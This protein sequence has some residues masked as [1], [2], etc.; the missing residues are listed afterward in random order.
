M[1]LM[2]CALMATSLAAA[3]EVS[4]VLASPEVRAEWDAWQERQGAPRSPLAC[5]EFWPGDA[6]LC[7]QV[8]EERHLRWVTEADLA[9][10]AVTPAALRAQVTADAANRPLAGERRRVEGMDAWYWRADG[11]WSLSGLFDPQRLVREV[12]SPLLAVAVPSDGVLLAWPAGAAPLDQVMAVAVQE[13]WTTQRNPVC[14]VIY[15][16]SGD[17]WLPYLE[18]VPKAAPQA[19]PAGDE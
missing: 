12:G 15:R 8:V 3:P 19:A 11:A 13:A 18:A 16:W 4:P 7:Y 9:R 1:T 6:L 10:W 5:E 17:K 14:P 2:I